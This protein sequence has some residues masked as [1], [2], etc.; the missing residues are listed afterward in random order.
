MSTKVLL[1]LSGALNLVLIANFFPGVYQTLDYKSG[2]PAK[3]IIEP[4]EVHALNDEKNIGLSDLQ[5]E[6]LSYGEIKYKQSQQQ[7]H[8]S[9]KYWQADDFSSKV[10]FFN[11]R[12][13]DDQNIRAALLER[14]GESALQN[15]VFKDAFYPLSR[16]ADFLTSAQQIALNEQRV[17]EQI[18]QLEKPPVKSQ[19]T[20]SPS[21]RANRPNDSD[22][23]SIIGEQAAFEYNLRHSYLSDKL[24]LS[25]VDFTEAKFRDTF[26]IM[27]TSFSATNVGHISSQVLIIQRNELKQV[28]GDEDALRVLASL[29]GR[30]DKLN[31]MAQKNDLTEEQVLFV[32]EIISQ[33]EM[34]MVEAYELRKTNPQRS[35]Q[36]MRDAALNKQ[37]QLYSYLGEDLARLVTR[38]FNKAMHGSIAPAGVIL[39]K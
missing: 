36:L 5:V 7:R 21:L 26:A 38:E 9:N 32:Y 16:H 2:G 39:R 30:F 11:K 22:V 18:N 1:V 28:L 31:R 20:N 25:G 27:S 33:S 23:S 12:L 34:E 14:F 24:R 17:R 19:I 3:E 29:D 8:V 4:I 10:A 6:I 13:L 35:A 37:Q 15:H